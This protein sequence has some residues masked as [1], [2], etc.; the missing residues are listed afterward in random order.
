MGKRVNPSPEDFPVEVYIHKNRLAVLGPVWA[1]SPSVTFE[2]FLSRFAIAPHA[3][4]RDM[5]SAPEDQSEERSL[6][7]SVD[8]IRAAASSR[9]HPFTDDGRFTRD[10]RPRFAN[11]YLHFDL[12]ATRDATGLAMVHYSPKRGR[13]VVDFVLEI[14]APEGGQIRIAAVETLIKALIRS[15]FHIACASGDQWGSV[16]LKQDLEAQGVQT[17]HISVDRTAEAHETL[18]EAF[19]SG[20]LDYYAY[21]PLFRNLEDLVLVH[22]GK[23]IDHRSTGSKDVSDA[24]AGALVSCFE[25]EKIGQIPEI[26]PIP[27]GLPSGADSGYDGGRRSLPE[28]DLG[29]YALPP[30]E[31][32]S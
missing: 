13:V 16:Q 10:L 3:A 8:P 26:V 5:A 28:D 15:G 4:L 1:F 22:G 11:Y 7:P 19:Y 9:Q 32:E 31:E 18:Q 17:K 25:G 29:F 21:E 20:F 2:H 30:G 6:Y 14:R 24:L 23:K 12:S 27:R